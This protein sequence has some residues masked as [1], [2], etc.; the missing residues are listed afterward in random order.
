MFSARHYC[1]RGADILDVSVT[2]SSWN[3]YE[4]KCN[5]DNSGTATIVINGGNGPYIKTLYDINN[6]I[7]TM[8][9]QIILQEFQLRHIH[10]KLKAAMVVFIK[11]Y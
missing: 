5:G 9:H 7:F 8:V 2:T 3:G 6:S 1:N 11:N 10:L 4:I